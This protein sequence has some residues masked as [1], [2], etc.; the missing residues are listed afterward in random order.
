MAARIL[1]PMPPVSST[2]MES[3]RR[4]SSAFRPVARLRKS[5]A[6]TF[7][8]ASFPSCSSVRLPRHRASATL[9][10]PTEPFAHF[11]T[12]AEVDWSDPE[13][14]IEYLVDYARVLAGGDRPFDEAATRDLVR[15]DV[16]RTRNIASL[17]NHDMLVDDGFSAPCP[18]SPRRRW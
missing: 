3:P 13:S 1:S 12:Q 9:A 11:V 18:R 16:A 7:P 6:S 14:V 10:P 15:R 17:Q 5:S 8:I 4:M 2:R